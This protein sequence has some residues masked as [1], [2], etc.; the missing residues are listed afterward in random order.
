LPGE[1]TVILHVD[2][3]EP[4]R[5]LLT[6]FLQQEGFAVKEAGTGA[7]ALR[8]LE[9][10]PD[11]IILDVNLPDSSGIDVCRK[12]KANPATTAIPVLHISGTYCS[13]AHRTNA[14][15]H[16][17]DGYLTKPVE[18][19]ELIAHVR[20]LLRMRQAEQEAR[21]AARHWRATFDALSDAIWLLDQDRR[22]LRCNTAMRELLGDPVSEKDV[23]D[24][25]QL[26]QA[27]F[28][29]A[30]PGLAPGARGPRHG[31]EGELLF[32]GRWFR[33]TE[34]PVA[35]EQGVPLGTIQVLGDITARKQAENEVRRLN[36]ELEQRV[37]QRT[38]ELE[39]ANK[40]LEAFCYSVSHDLRAPARGIIGLSR[41]LLEDHATYLPAEVQRF[42]RLL[43]DN[44]EQMA[45]LIDAL[46]TFSRLS[47]QPLNKRT[48]AVAD[49]VRLCLEELEVERNGR[50][51]EVVLEELPCCQ[52]D[53]A[54]LKQVWSNL[55]S[56]AWKYT[57]KRST[58]RIEIGCTPPL[59]AGRA[60]YVRDNGVG[61]DMRYAAK[62]FGVFQ[63][64]HRAE[65][66]PGTGVGLAIVQ[67]IVQRH[68]GRVWAEAEVERGATFYFTV[69]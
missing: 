53:P 43:H 68:G 42:L 62:L 67:R 30:P 5:R 38:T 50:T 1:Q 18:P 57:G 24:L 44:G 33:A 20:A 13:S 61:F 8:L 36:E 65:E 41:I 6:R 55:L 51:V 25:H 27:A 19:H 34:D 60:Y 7:D 2:D 29:P 39:G 32:R 63:R 58:A 3:N 47:R 69:P 28:S 35:D 56:N 12:I 45:N 17:A 40:E 66:Y 48:V 52:A 22:L 11:L 37:Q 31:R 23:G 16:G 10:K 64:L 26:L 59:A 21:T 14:L 54:L 15:E 46:L 9:E 49:L 4:S